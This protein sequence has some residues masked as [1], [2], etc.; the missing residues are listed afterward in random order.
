MKQIKNNTIHIR[1]FRK[2]DIKKK[3]LM[4]LNNKKLNKFISTRKK[5]TNLQRCIKLFKYLKKK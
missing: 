5:K 1:N 2:N 3:F 4:G